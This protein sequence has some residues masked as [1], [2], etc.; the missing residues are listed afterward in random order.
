[1]AAQDTQYWANGYG[2]QAR[3]LGGV[4]I[5]SDPDI[6]AVFYNP[7]ALSLEANLQL[8]ISL[9]ALQYS[10]LSYSSPE[11]SS[12]IP[13]NSSWA[14]L[15]NMFAGV[16]RIGGKDSPQ[17]LAYSILTRQLYTFDAQIRGVPLDSFAPPPPS[18]FTSS[19]GNA[20]AHQSL[21]ETWVGL[22]YATTSGEHW[23][24][25][26]SMF[27]AIRGQTYSQT[28]SAQ[29]V[30]EVGDAALGVNE[31]DFSYYNW[32][33]LFKLGAQYKGSDWTAG[34]TITTPRLDLFGG[35]QVGATRSYVDNGVAGGGNSAQ[36]ATNYQ[37]QLGATYHTPFSIGAGAAHKWKTTDVTV[38]AEWFA[39]VP[40]FTIIPAEP[41]IP[42]TGGPAIPMALTAQYRSV[43]NWG[44]G[45]R[46]VLSPHMNGY[47]AFRTDE[48]TIPPGVKSVG[49][50]INWDLL[51]ANLGVQGTVGPASITLGFDTSWG[52]QSGARPVGDSPPGL[53]VLPS[54][55]ASYF[56]IVTAIAFSYAFQL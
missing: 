1:M 45:V 12:K 51:H 34:L 14:S 40:K 26:S 24:F 48:T 55:S 5:G 47:F 4:V 29:A 13:A 21:G 22:T 25:G 52:N 49:T 7:G 35:S 18:P 33:V 2:T 54:V 37:S 53:P 11:A 27:V 50:L 9:N 44:A 19:I 41:F 8:L 20:Q 39:A 42:Q 31:Y 3:L 10:S 16:V 46:Q 43:F 56:N 38:S 23:G 30:D 36:I 6:S 15:P 32:A 17:R 28:V